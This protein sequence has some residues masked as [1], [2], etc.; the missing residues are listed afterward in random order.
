MGSVLLALE[1]AGVR[2]TRQVLANLE[3]ASA[4]VGVK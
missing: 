3:A 4:A 1:L 2:I